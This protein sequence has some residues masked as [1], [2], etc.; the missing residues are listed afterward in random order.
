MPVAAQSM[1][2][3]R[4][5]MHAAAVLETPPR[6]HEEAFKKKSFATLK[7]NPSYSGLEILKLIPDVRAAVLHC[8]S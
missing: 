5:R 7:Q 6:F 2:S 1:F 8:A 3:T 4:R